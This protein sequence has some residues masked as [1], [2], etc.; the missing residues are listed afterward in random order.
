MNARKTNAFINASCILLPIFL[1]NQ[2]VK[3]NNSCLRLF[4]ISA[5]FVVSYSTFVITSTVFSNKAILEFENYFIA[6]KKKFVALTFSFM[7]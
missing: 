1:E 2:E 7:C 3:T 5:Y 4:F 6:L